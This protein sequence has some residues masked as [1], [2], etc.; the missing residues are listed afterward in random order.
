MRGEMNNNN[1]LENSIIA[2][3]ERKE[4]SPEEEV[5]LPQ[6][7]F[8]NLLKNGVEIMQLNIFLEGCYQHHAIYGDTPIKTYSYDFFV[9]ENNQLLGNGS[10]T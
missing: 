1:P 6:Q 10:P 2:L 8:L 9:K 7:D 4:N 5:L 3:E